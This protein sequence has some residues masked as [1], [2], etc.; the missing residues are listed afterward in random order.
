MKIIGIA[1]ADGYL[2]EPCTVIRFDNQ[3]KAIENI[4]SLIKEENIEK[5]VIGI[6]EGRSAEY[7]RG[8]GNNLKNKIS[9]D[10]TYWDE[11]LSTQEAI[12]KSI[13]SGM[14]REKRKNMEDAFAAAV[15]L[16]SYLDGNV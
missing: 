3:N 13:E 8:F 10:I 14:G 4:V 12:E 15:M 11:T 5:I 9:M 2:A 7:T 6:S 1:I 16:Q